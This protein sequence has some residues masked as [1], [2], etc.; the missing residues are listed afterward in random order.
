L[1]P[2]LPKTQW[3]KLN[4]D[5]LTRTTFQDEKVEAGKKYYYFLNAVDSSGNI[6]APSEVVAET[7]P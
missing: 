4:G 2:E 5:L 7:V 3:V 1:D 6:S